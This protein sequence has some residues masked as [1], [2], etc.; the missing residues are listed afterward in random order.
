MVLVREN[1][2]FL[3]KLLSP[4]SQCTRSNQKR[5]FS[6]AAADYLAQQT[7]Y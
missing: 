7:H 5:I 6:I 1:P 3:I 4:I 2:R